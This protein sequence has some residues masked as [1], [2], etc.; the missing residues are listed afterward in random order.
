MSSDFFYFG[1]KFYMD[2]LHQ[3]NLWDLG[4]VVKLLYSKLLALYTFWYS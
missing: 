3:D 2:P 4:S 1:C